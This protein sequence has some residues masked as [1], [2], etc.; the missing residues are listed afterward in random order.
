MLIHKHLHVSKGKYRVTEKFYK[1]LT[2]KQSGLVQTST[3]AV[4]VRTPN[5]G[6]VTLSWDQR[7]M[8]FIEEV[9]VPRRWQPPTGQPYDLNKFS[10]E[11]CKAFRHALEKEQVVYEILVRSTQ[12]YYKGPM[13]WKKTIG[14][15]MHEG[16]W[17]TDYFDM[18]RA[19]QDGEET[20]TDHISNSLDDG[21]SSRFKMG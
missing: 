19:A 21:S 7:Y 18:C 1:T 17:K 8:A 3:G 14:H 9:G 10:A 16:L 5:L 13:E 4:A 11:G 15:Y 20:L 2:G 12:L 6:L